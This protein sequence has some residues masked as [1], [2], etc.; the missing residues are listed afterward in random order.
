MVKDID[1]DKL[2]LFTLVEYLLGV[3]SPSTWI[4][5]TPFSSNS[6]E[7]SFTD[8]VGMNVRLMLPGLTPFQLRLTCG[9]PLYAARLTMFTAHFL[10]LGLFYLPI[11]QS[12][13]LV[14]CSSLAQEK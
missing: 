9:L 7:M 4:L 14:T 6:S 12:P 5:R 13:W 10:P 11:L 8:S 3:T 2:A 1:G